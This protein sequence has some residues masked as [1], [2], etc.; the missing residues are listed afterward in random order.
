MVLDSV[1]YVSCTQPKQHGRCV[2]VY[3]E[4][5]WAACTAMHIPRRH[6]DALD[7]FDLPA[8]AAQ[9][10][11]P[12]APQQPSQPSASDAPAF[13][14][15]AAPPPASKPF[16]PLGKR[17][18][19][20]SA[21]TRGAGATPAASTSAGTDARAQSRSAATPDA[22]GDLAQDLAELLTGLAERAYLTFDHVPM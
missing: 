4:L 5:P 12:P 20:R 7:R 3:I 22:M 18:S 8:P 21:A 16:D 10:Q 6:A 2:T 15:H 14:A 11:I 17:A 13:E 9:P 19:R 1:V